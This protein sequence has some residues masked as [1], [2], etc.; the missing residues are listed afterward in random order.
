MARNPGTD[1]LNFMATASPVQDIDPLANLLLG[2]RKLP[3]WRQIP[4]TDRWSARPALFAYD[5][6]GN[7]DLY[8][9]P[10]DYNG[11]V[12]H[13]YFRAGIVVNCPAPNDLNNFLRDQVAKLSTLPIAVN[14]N[15]PLLSYVSSITAGRPRDLTL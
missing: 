13:L 9:V 4:L 5:V 12:H 10:M 14:A 6:Y 1:R 11:L 3:L 8:W 15:N 7:P 2:L